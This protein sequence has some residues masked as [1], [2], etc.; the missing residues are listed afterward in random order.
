MSQYSPQNRAR[1]VLSLSRT[2]TT[3]E[4][5]AALQ[6][7]S[8]TGLENGWVQEIGASKDYLPAFDRDGHPFMP[9]YEGET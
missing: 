8:A 3:A 7:L 2:I 6:A 4:Y 9:A 5:E 1:E